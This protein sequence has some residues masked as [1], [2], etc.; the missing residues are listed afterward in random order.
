MTTSYFPIHPICVL[1][2][3]ANVN[4]IID[5]IIVNFET[6]STATNSQ[7][8][9]YHYP[10][11]VTSQLLLPF[12]LLR[13]WTTAAHRQSWSL[14]V[15]FSLIVVSRELLTQQSHLSLSINYIFVL[16]RHCAHVI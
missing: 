16:N 3:I 7:Y 11:I 9:T 4:Y 14:K 1:I 6:K 8:S 10:S 5:Y 12:G 15:K 13:S 2:K